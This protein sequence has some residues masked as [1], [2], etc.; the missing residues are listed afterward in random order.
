MR[1]DYQIRPDST[2][3]AARVTRGFT[4]VELVVVIVI[5]S[6]LSAIAVP[7]FFDNQ[8][9]A[10]RAFFEDLSAGLRLARQVAVAS[11]CP[12]RVT[13][14]VG[15]YDARQQA[16][17]AGRCDSSDSTW[18]VPVRMADGETLTGAVP[19]G[20]TISPASTIVFDGVG[21]TNLGA[22]RTLNVGTHSL[23]VRA[24]SGYIQEN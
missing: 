19:S 21:A 13:I 8:A 12:V 22:D 20:V 24:G 1:N 7:R 4:L 9:F 16:A 14:T 23:T 6:V 5:V 17:A 18:S 10:E 2:P 3:A 11:G 15:G